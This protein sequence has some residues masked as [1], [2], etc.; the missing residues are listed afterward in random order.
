[1]VGMQHTRTTEVYFFI[2]FTTTDCKLRKKKG[3]KERDK[4]NTALLENKSVY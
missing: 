2:R 1:M 3:Y 4:N